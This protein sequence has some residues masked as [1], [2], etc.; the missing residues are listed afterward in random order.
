M[1]GFID[2]SLELVGPDGAVVADA[3]DTIGL[4][5]VVHYTIPQDGEYTARVFLVGYLGGPEAVY[6]LTLG[7]VP[8]PTALFPPGG[9][10]GGTVE[11]S[12]FGPN[13]PPGAHV[14]VRRTGRPAAGDLARAAGLSA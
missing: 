2:A 13:V 8:Y 6:R 12:A 3:Q 10:R 4:D 7:D 5:P 9:Q 14:F 1:S 11:L